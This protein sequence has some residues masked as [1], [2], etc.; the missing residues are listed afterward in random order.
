MLVVVRK[1]LTDHSADDH[2]PDRR[3]SHWGT[4]L[5]KIKTNATA[6]VVIPIICLLQVPTAA[7][8]QFVGERVRVTLVSDLMVGTV[9]AIGQ[10]EVELILGDG[11]E[12]AVAR[13]DIRRVERSIVRRQWK[14]GL[15]IGAAPGVVM[16]VVGLCCLD[17]SSS[18]FS[19]LSDQEAGVIGGIVLTG[20]GGLVGSGIGALIRREGWE[21]IPGW[22][23]GGAQP[24]LLLALQPGQEGRRHLLMGLRLRLLR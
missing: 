19:L 16:T 13:D 10:D 23:M 4:V 8:G 17:D 18:D 6:T 2:V 3:R 24:D 20:L 7:V 22:D 21:A 9:A 5:T 14:K 12:L 15:V 1:R 11:R